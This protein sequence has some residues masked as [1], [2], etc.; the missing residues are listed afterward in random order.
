[1]PRTGEVLV[2]I[3]NNPH[4]LAI[5]RQQRWYRIPVG[6]MRKW[7]AKRWPP[8]WI[9]FYHTKALAP[10]EHG[11]FFY[12]RVID[13][14]T[15]FRWQL[16]PDEPHDSRNNRQYY[17][18]F[19]EPLRDLPQPILSRRW[20]RIVFIQTTHEKF[21]SAVEINDLYDESPLEDRLWVEFKRLQ[22]DAER[23]EFVKAKGKDYALD[24]AI[25]CHKSNLDIE[26]DGDLYHANRERAAGDNLRDNNLKTVGWRVL[27]FNTVQIREEMVEYCVPTVLENINRLGGIDDGRLIPRQFDPA[28]LDALPQPSLFD[29]WEQPREK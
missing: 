1:M 6:S 7:L 11:V 19:F 3:L 9:A 28:R 18:L 14:R 10:Q 25:Y 5:A 16:F 4:D 22:I 12:A 24:F 17:Q 8:E 27:R 26:T 29:D 13:I 2:A 21:F 20:R 23:Q 15:A